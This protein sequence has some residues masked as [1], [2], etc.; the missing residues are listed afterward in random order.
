[1]RSIALSRYRAEHADRRGGG[2]TAVVLD[3]LADTLSA[4]DSVEQTVDA[5]ALK[6]VIERFL[7]T[8]TPDART[9]FMQRYYLMAPVKTIAR[10]QGMSTGKV[11]MLL[12]RTRK[13]LQIFLNKEGYL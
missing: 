10:E 9:V 2:Q 5:L 6:A 3:E 4:E 11:K 8:L 13:K 12:L 1:M 7:D